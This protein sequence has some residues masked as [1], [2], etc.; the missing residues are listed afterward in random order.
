MATV[1]YY[2]GDVTAA[3]TGFV[4]HQENCSTLR[5]MGLATQMKRRFP[6]SV[7]PLAE[8]IPGTSVIRG[9]VVNLFGQVT[10]GKPTAAEPAVTRQAYFYEALVD[11]HRQIAGDPTVVVSFPYMIGCGLASGSWPVYLALITNFATWLSPT[12]TVNIWQLPAQ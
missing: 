2:Y 6:D 10:T 11:L 8:R 9:R 5:T 7:V 1:N 4:V 12:A 3:P